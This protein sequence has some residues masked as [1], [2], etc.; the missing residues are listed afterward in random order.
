ME[1]VESVEAV[2]VAGAVVTTASKD[3][4]EDQSG[5]DGLGSGPRAIVVRTCLSG[6]I[7]PVMDSPLQDEALLPSKFS[8]SLSESMVPTSRRNSVKY[9]GSRPAPDEGCGTDDSS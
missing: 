9:S 5:I 4:G 2:E 7:A 3:E 8:W 6:T 1:S